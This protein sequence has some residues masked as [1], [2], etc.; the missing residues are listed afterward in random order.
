MEYNTSTQEYVGAAT[1]PKHVPSSS[2]KKRKI[3]E[4]NPTIDKPELSLACH[5][6]SAMV[7]G[8][9]KRF[10]NVVGFE[11]TDSSFDQQKVADFISGCIK[12]VYNSGLIIKAVVSDGSSQNEG[13]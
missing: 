10:K 11:F 12:E 6:L 8:L 1:I 7:C 13:V 9:T 4:D 5:G 2:G 3:V